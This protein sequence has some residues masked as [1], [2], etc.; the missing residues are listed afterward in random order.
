LRSF[1]IMYFGQYTSLKEYGFRGKVK[2]ILTYHLE[3][4]STSFDT[5]H[6]IDTSLWTFKNHYYFSVEGDFI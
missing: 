3:S 2:S 1:I 6:L 4:L 5:T